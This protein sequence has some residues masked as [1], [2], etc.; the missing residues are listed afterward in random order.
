[1]NA[2]QQHILNTLKHNSIF[3][4]VL[5]LSLLFFLYKGVLYLIIGSYVPM[6]VIL[7]IMTLFLFSSRKSESGFKKTIG[8]W[9]ILLIIWSMVRLLLSLTNQF[10]KPIPESH[11]S[12]QLGVLGTIFS[13]LMLFGGIYLWRNKSRLF[14]T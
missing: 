2:L 7:I 4:A 6:I 5:G 13:L 8:L 14:K 1:M 12:E 9:A 3:L 10:I 11:V